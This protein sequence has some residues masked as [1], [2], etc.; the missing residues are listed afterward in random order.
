VNGPAAEVDVDREAAAT[1]YQDRKRALR[2]SMRERR[3]LVAPDEAARAGAQ[4]AALLDGIASGAGA[5]A[6]LFASMPGEIDTLPIEACLRD[7]GFAIAFPRVDGAVLRLHRAP[8][9]AL[10]PAGPFRI[11]EPGPSAPAVEPGELSLV[12]VPGLAFDRHGGRLGFGRGYYDG[13]LAS[14]PAALRVAP[15]FPFQ[16]AG[17]VPREPHDQLVDVLLVVGAQP[18]LLHT[19]ARARGLAFPSKETH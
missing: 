11:D 18:H 7:A 17:E 5:C 13:L 8:R 2:A 12:I 1:G 16:L 6:L 15:C 19:N 4:A 14:A 10:S 9:A 3:A